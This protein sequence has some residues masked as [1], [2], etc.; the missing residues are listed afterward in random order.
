LFYTRVKKRTESPLQDEGL[1]AKDNTSWAV[2]RSKLRRQKAEVKFKPMMKSQ[3]CAVCTLTDKT[4]DQG[5]V[6]AKF[7]LIASAEEH[8][9][10]HSFF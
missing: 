9:S 5:Q 7:L 6:V 1:L 8:V 2:D 10:S 4:V 3:P